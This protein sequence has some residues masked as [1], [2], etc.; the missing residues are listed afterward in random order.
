M[1]SG[2]HAL[3]HGEAFGSAEW[4]RLTGSMLEL[5]KRVETPPA[6]LEGLSLPPR[7]YQRIA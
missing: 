5:V 1:S 7:I 2:N 3:H 6:T 4:E